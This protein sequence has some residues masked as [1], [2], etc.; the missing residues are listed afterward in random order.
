LKAR[1][2]GDDARSLASACRELM[3]PDA[4]TAGP[5]ARADVSKLYLACLP[6]QLIRQMVE[7]FVLDV[8]VDERHRNARLVIRVSALL[9]TPSGASG[10]LWVEA[11]ADWP[12]LTPPAAEALLRLLKRVAVRRAGAQPSRG[13]A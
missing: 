7:A 1:V 11:P 13:P 2:I 10:G 5:L 4:E 6:L 9:P 3:L 8:Y 12:V